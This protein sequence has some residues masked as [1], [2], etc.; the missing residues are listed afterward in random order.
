[1]TWEGGGWCDVPVCT[2]EYFKPFTSCKMVLWICSG[3]ED[4]NVKVVSIQTTEL[5]AKWSEGESVV[6]CSCT[7]KKEV[8][9]PNLAGR[10]PFEVKN[11]EMA[12]LKGLGYVFIP[13]CSMYVIPFPRAWHLG[14]PP[15]CSPAWTGATSTLL[16]CR[17]STASMV[18][19]WGSSAS[20][21]NVQVKCTASSLSSLE[22]VERIAVDH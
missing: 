14:I 20:C 16:C 4:L 11:K 6:P 18:F 19:V 3:K 12:K 21:C 17:V 13:C 10:W 15:L 2:P 22:R 7:W 8:Q 5:M 9:G 1:M